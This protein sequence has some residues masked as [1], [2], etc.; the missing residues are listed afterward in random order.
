MTNYDRYFDKL[1]IPLGAAA[2]T[3]P[4]YCLFSIEMAVSLFAR[5]L[6]KIIRR[7]TDNVVTVSQDS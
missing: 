3:P 5:L 4:L 7:I 1:Q 6:V 2:P